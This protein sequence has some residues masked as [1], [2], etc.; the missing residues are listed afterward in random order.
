LTT[1]SKV[2]LEKH[3]RV[4]RPEGQLRFFDRQT[5][6]SR[7]Q[8]EEAKLK[9][10]KF[11]RKRGV[12]SAALQRDLML[13]RVEN[14]EAVYGQSQVET[15]S[16][17]RRVQALEKEMSDLPRRAVTQIRTSD[18]PEL[19]RA[20]KAT[21][22]DLQLKKTQLLTKFEPGHQLLQ[23]VERQI[24][25][26]RAAIT[27]EELTPVRDETTDKDSE[28]EW[29]N[30]ELQKARVDLTVL[31]A[32]EAASRP[33]IG[34][35]LRTARSLGEDAITQGELVS[36]EKASEESYLL[37]VRKRE[38]A[39]MGDAL[40]QGGIVN[41]AIAE[42]PVVPALPVWPPAVVALAGLVGAL[43]SGTGAAFVADYLDP[44]LRTPEEVLV[45][46][47]LP[48]LAS[49]PATKKRTRLSA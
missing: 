10:L 13:Q 46:L 32:R 5:V 15:A 17:E 44:A 49:L 23:E 12:I 40:D 36:D 14:L 48:V 38:E 21:L 28:Y 22:L 16:T 7:K 24:Q 47:D 34:E 8:L 43:V 42:E 19:A 20:L 45:F 3:M 18:N 6:E 37:Y 39:R 35:Y 26:A 30:G 31:Q 33:E 2:Y 1:L 11:T 9:L 27:D 41:V 4:H 29:A 25:Q